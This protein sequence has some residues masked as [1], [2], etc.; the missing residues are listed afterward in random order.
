[1]AVAVA[2]AIVVV[3]GCGLVPTGK[4]SNPGIFSGCLFLANSSARLRFCDFFKKEKVLTTRKF[5]VN[6]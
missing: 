5:F 4:S 1:M 6:M 2:A 3:G